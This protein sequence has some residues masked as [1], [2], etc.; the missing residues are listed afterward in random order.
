LPRIVT[1]NV[2]SCI[3]VDRKLAPARIAEVL[4]VLE[5]DI[6]ALQELDVGRVRSGGI[7]QAHA[8]AELL[9]MK[10]H[11]HPAVSVLEE[12]YGDAILSDLPMRLVKA[13]ALPGLTTRPLLEPRGA[14]WAEIM[15]DGQPLQVV[16]TH[17]G[18]MGRERIAQAQALL[19]PDW[20]GH[21][22]CRKPAILTGDFN[23]PPPTA[24]FRLLRRHLGEAQDQ[25]PGRRQASFPSRFPLLSLDHVFFAGPVAIGRAW[26]DRTPRARVASDHLPLVVDFEIVAPASEPGDA[27]ARGAAAALSR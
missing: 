7:D 11:F 6:V 17:L 21:P 26:T 8:I 23:A 9:G 16:N 24:A 27:P 18:L 19:G 4:A 5:P 22:D 12:Q 15:I 14:L 10:M 25:V 20:L 2:H 1:Y 3:G 13:G